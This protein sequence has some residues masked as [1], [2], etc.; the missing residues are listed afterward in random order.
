MF[1][2]YHFLSKFCF[3]HALVFVRLKFALYFNLTLIPKMS[4]LF[5]FVKMLNHMMTLT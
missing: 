4:S 5:S 2:H 3:H 1:C